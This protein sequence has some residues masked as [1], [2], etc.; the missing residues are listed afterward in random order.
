MLVPEN[1][2]LGISADQIT[3]STLGCSTH[4]SGIGSEVV[5]GL[6][7]EVTPSRNEASREMSVREDDDVRVVNL[8]TRRG[9]LGLNVSSASPVH[10]LP[11][12]RWISLI[13]AMTRSTRSLIC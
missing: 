10:R 13:L 9:I 6:Q 1:G 11:T 12:L 4:P 3:L 8:V 2:K 7:G 5:S